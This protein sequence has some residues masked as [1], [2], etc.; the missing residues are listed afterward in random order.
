MKTEKTELIGYV[1]AVKNIED[2]NNEF[3]TDESNFVTTPMYVSKDQ[4]HYVADIDCAKIWDTLKE[5]NKMGDNG[6]YGGSIPE[7]VH[8]IVYTIERP[9]KN[10]VNSTVVTLEP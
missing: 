7:V 3:V 10:I 9:K 6:D 8:R 1:I 2:Y 5:I 4:G